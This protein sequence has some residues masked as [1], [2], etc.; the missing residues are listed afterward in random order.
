MSPLSIQK[1]LPKGPWRKIAI[2]ACLFVG[3]VAL[4]FYFGS[5]TPLEDLKRMATQEARHKIDSL[6]NQGVSPLDGFDPRITEGPLAISQKDGD[7]GTW[8]WSKAK[9]LSA[10]IWDTLGYDGK[11]NSF[12]C[13]C[14]IDRTGSSGGR[15]D[16]NS[17]GV[18]P[19]K[20]PSRASRLEWEHIVPASVI[21]QN[22]SCWTQGAAQCVDSSGKSFKGRSCCEIADPYYNMA[23]TDPVNLVPA[24]GEING[25]RS[26][27]DFGMITGEAR[28]YGICDME[29]DSSQRLAEPPAEKRGDIARVWA[30]MSRAY[31]IPV[32]PNEAETYRQWMVE[33]PISDEEMRLNEAIERSGHRSNPF[34]LEDS[35][36]P[37]PSQ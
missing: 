11:I 25:D 26:N 18:E 20:S 31:G 29:I 3:S 23:A 4:P 6:G 7:R 9:R 34:V 8:S 13:G 32:T 19:R 10:D 24:V 16:L 36:N 37:P 21:A 27:Y 14:S 30:Y 35:I 22:K 12:Y 17:C 15:V 33:D 1:F 2:G 28:Q 5:D